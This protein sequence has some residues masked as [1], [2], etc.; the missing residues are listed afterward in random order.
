MSNEEA[1][2]KAFQILA[3]LI[4]KDYSAGPDGFKIYKEDVRK[5]MVKAK[6]MALE[7]PKPLAKDFPKF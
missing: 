3:G 6:K 5:H 2:E 1:V 7:E 4:H